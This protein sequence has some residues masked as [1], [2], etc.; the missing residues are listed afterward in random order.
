MNVTKP[1]VVKDFE[2]LEAIIQQKVKHTFPYGFT[3]DLIYYQD[4]DGNRVSALPFDTEEKYY[5]IRMTISQAMQI[6]ADDDDYD[7]DGELKEEIKS[8]YE[9]KFGEKMEE[10]NEEEEHSY[11]DD[12]EDSQVADKEEEGEAIY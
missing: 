8:D 9:S 7:D 4:K 2:K 12:G 5:L 10:S 6:V 3:E 11:D 1:R